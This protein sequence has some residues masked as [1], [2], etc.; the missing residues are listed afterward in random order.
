MPTSILWLDRDGRRLAKREGAAGLAPLQG[1]GMDAAAVVSGWRQVSVWSPAGRSSAQRKELPHGVGR[2]LS[3]TSA[4][5]TELMVLASVLQHLFE[6]VLVAV[7]QSV[8]KCQEIRT[9]CDDCLQL[10]QGRR[11]SASG[12]P[13]LSYVP[14][15]P[16]PRSR[17][18]KALE[19]V[20][21]RA[22][23]VFRTTGTSADLCSS[24][25][26]SNQRRCW[27]CR[28]MK[29]TAVATTTA[30]GSAVSSSRT[31]V[32]SVYISGWAL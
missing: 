5:A 2:P 10:L 32:Q 7:K 24:H 22:S 12:T 17:A 29:N 9:D 31:A 21:P 3:A 1:H 14:T 25:L 23:S 18:A 15:L 28:W 20:L 19:V 11:R 30:R 26:G 13:A 8:R 27:R 6:I 16:W 4:E